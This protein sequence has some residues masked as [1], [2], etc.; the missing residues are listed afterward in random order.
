MSRWLIYAVLA[1]AVLEAIVLVAF[2]ALTGRGID[3]RDQL[4]NLAAGLFLMLGICIA[5][6]G[7]SWVGLALCLGAAGVAHVTDLKRRLAKK[8][9]G[10]DSSEGDR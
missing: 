2:N 8:G 3:W 5:V 6:E 7:A 1:I 4:A 9:S 10:R